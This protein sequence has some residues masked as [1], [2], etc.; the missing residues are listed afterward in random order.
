MLGLGFGMYRAVQ[1]SRQSRHRRE[2]EPYR[3]LA[4]QMAEVTRGYLLATDFQRILNQ[5]HE[6]QQISVAQANAYLRVYGFQPLRPRRSVFAADRLYFHPVI[7]RSF[8]FEGLPGHV[9]PQEENW[10]DRL[11]NIRQSIER[12]FRR[13]A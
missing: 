13:S 12:V 7:R 10:T 8:T 1:A 5:W 3:E 6:T 9:E 2:G 4:F 11:G